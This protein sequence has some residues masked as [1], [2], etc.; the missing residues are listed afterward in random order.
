MKN[1]TG[2]KD[3]IV[4][5]TIFIFLSFTF[6]ILC[7]YAVKVVVQVSAVER[8]PISEIFFLG[9]ILG[10]TITGIQIRREK[11]VKKPY[12]IE[13]V[14]SPPIIKKDILITK[15]DSK[16]SDYVNK[17]LINSENVVQMLRRRAFEKQVELFS[18]SDI[19]EAGDIDIIYKPVLPKYAGWL[20]KDYEGDITVGLGFV[21]DKD[22]V[23]HSVRVISSSADPA[24][25][26]LALQYVK[27]LIFDN[28]DKKPRS[29][30]IY[31]KIVSRPFRENIED[32]AA[33]K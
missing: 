11:A 33:G 31:V 29:G 24:V 4:S 6:H 17:F 25:D 2:L 22:G 7:G 3:N 16:K 19:E 12:F 27:R 21:I 26:L 9:P 28:P 5:L 8:I 18:G 1:I 32:M 30:I 23:P 10:E 15:T 13:E 20:S 14:K